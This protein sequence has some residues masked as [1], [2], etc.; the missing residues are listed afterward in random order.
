MDVGAGQTT[1]EAE[2]PAPRLYIGDFVAFKFAGEHGDR[3]LLGVRDDTPEGKV[4]VLCVG[5]A[6]VHAEQGD[7][8]VVDRS[9]LRPSH[10]VVSASDPGGQVGL[11]VGVDTVVDLV[12]LEGRGGCSLVAR[13][14]PPVELRCV[15]EL[16]MGD[17][18]TSGPWL[19]RVVELSV[20]VD[21][22]FA[23]S[24]T[25][26]PAGSARRRAS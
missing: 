7:L 24:T 19:G 9:W 23:S 6:V 18:V 20:D 26:P 17:Y 4:D 13:G 15:T 14:V 5:G 8:T 16:G 1:G 10:M 22:L 12:E 11:V 3:G 25:A 2:K 21:V